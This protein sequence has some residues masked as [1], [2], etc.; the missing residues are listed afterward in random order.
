MPASGLFQHIWLFKGVA[1]REDGSWEAP[2]V[3]GQG[4]GGFLLVLSHSK[5]CSGLSLWVLIPSQ[6][7]MGD[8]PCVHPHPEP[9][10]P[11][12]ATIRAK[13]GAP[14]C[15]I[16]RPGTSRGAAGGCPPLQH[17][18]MPFVLFGVWGNSAALGFS[19]LFWKFKTFA[20]RPTRALPP[21]R[22]ALG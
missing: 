20:G 9:I 22:E 13:L 5:L 4:A 6:S 21:R 2:T 7:P 3:P 17:T 19:L 11:S 14:L 12:L 18:G 15:H 10:F 16:P 1:S 8:Q